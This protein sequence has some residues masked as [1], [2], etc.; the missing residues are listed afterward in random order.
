MASVLIHA[1]VELQGRQAVDAQRP[2]QAQA[3]VVD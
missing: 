2:R 3:G 1:H